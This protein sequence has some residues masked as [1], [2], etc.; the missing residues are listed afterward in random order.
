MQRVVQGQASVIAVLLCC[1]AIGR[2]KS[3]DNGCTMLSLL[4]ASCKVQ[5]Q[6]SSTGCV[7]L[8]LQSSAAVHRRA[9]AAAFH[10]VL[11]GLWECCEDRCHQSRSVHSAL[12]ADRQV[13]RHMA[14]VGAFLEL[15]RL[16]GKIRC[17][18]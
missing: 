10:L 15:L 17:E 9:P 11:Q 14:L 4:M 1:M 16:L 18:L 5:R 8:L 13:Q 3:S 12:G 7:F 6:A 2:E